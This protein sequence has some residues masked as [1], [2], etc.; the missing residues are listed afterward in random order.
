MQ[1][2]S[3]VK[4]ILTLQILEHQMSLELLPDMLEAVFVDVAVTV[5]LFGL[6]HSFLREVKL[7][8]CE[9]AVK[10]VTFIEA[11]ISDFMAHVEL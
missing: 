4:K 2:S 5:D 3:C 6:V 1:L 8:K 10:R 7:F 9:L 11:V